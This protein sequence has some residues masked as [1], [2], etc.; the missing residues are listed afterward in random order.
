MNGSLQLGF[1]VGSVTLRT[2]PGQSLRDMSRN[3]IIRFALSSCPVLLAS[4]GV[5]LVIPIDRA[6][7]A[8]TIANGTRG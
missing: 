3:V 6:I 7:E 4:I 2:Q 1:V 5:M 8:A